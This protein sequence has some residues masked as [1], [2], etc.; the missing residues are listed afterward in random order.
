MRDTVMFAFCTS[1]LGAGVVAGSALSDTLRTDTL[2]QQP[3]GTVMIAVLVT[4]KKLSVVGGLAATAA[5][6]TIA[7]LVS[8]G[9]PS[10]AN[11]TAIGPAVPV[12]G[13]AT[14]P[15]NVTWYL[16]KQFGVTPRR[17]T[18]PL[19]LRWY[20]YPLLHPIV[21]LSVIG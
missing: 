15:Q 18:I 3:R 10:I 19:P 13:T 16:A 2:R 12:E 14:L 8:I 9:S 1:I 7:L 20:T 6:V 4:Q 5:G 17:V 11:D 21:V